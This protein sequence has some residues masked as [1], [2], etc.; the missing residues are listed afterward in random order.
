MAAVE[1]ADIVSYTFSHVGKVRE[2]NQDSVRLCDP[3]DALTSADGHLYGLADGMGGY[4]HGGVASSLALETFFET[5]YAANGVPPAQKLKVGVQNAN[6]SVYQTAHR[7]GAGRMGTTLTA[8]NIVGRTLFVAHVGDSRAYLVRDHVSKCLTNDHTRV[9][10]LVRMKVLAPEKVRNHSQ[11]SMLEKCLGVELFVQPDIF[12]L[13]VQEGD[14]IILCSD[15]V[16]GVIED[17]EFATF[18]EEREPS[19]L[20]KDVVDFAMERG[21]DDNLSMVALYLRRLAPTVAKHESD[22]RWLPLRALRRIFG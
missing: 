14:V 15:G 7:L 8:V 12:K 11:R 17:D 13:Q 2:D 1:V 21:S 9:G 22:N 20:C 3:A 18:V 6:L 4:A 5:F 10:E 19:D 16:W